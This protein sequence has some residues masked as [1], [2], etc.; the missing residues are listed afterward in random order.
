MLKTDVLLHKKGFV[1]SQMVATVA[2]FL[3]TMEGEKK[4]KKEESFVTEARKSCN[5]NGL[6]PSGG[7]Q[8]YA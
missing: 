6:V 1:D 7:S 2:V 5:H 8:G 3:M 4:K